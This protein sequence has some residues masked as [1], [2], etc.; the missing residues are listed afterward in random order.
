MKNIVFFKKNMV[1]FVAIMICSVSFFSGIVSSKSKLKY[2]EKIQNLIEDFDQ[3]TVK[4]TEDNYYLPTGGQY[5]GPFFVGK[6][7]ANF[8]NGSGWVKR[9][10]R[11]LLF[12]FGPYG[13]G[14]VELDKPFFWSEPLTFYSNSSGRL[15]G[16]RILVAVRY[17]FGNVKYVEDRAIVKGWCFLT[18]F[19]IDYLILHED[20]TI[21]PEDDS[22]VN[23]NYPIEN[24]GTSEFLEV[25][26]ND[27][28]EEMR[29]YIKFNIS[30]IPE[31]AFIHKA[32]LSLNYC[33]WDGP[34]E[35]EIGVYRV[36]NNWDEET[37][38]W[39]NQPDFSNKCE[40][41]WK[42]PPADPIRLEYWDITDLA[43]GW[44]DVDIPNHGIVVKF[45]N[46]NFEDF[47]KRVFNSK[48]AAN[49]KN[50]PL[51][52]INYNHPPNK[53]SKPSGLHFLKIGKT[54]NFSTST[55]D[56]DGDR[57]FF[58]F[59][60]GDDT[61]SGWVGPFDYGY[62]GSASHSWN[63]D[64]NYQIRVKAKDT[65]GSESEWSTPLNI[66]VYN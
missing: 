61:N 2:E 35:P 47:T 9:S 60:W 27:D 43:R 7:S 37:I 16:R 5:V 64:G 30:S 15:F 26:V 28:I 6:I 22:F 42:I 29:S 36:F 8:F 1:L 57:V 12:E 54:Y 10:G 40:Y 33:G 4:C 31:N 53:P 44:Y 20:L 32:L 21:L 48:E 41:H 59:D 56:T 3:L 24:Y 34:N 25:S 17:F 46:S 52:V 39:D 11:S 19:F 18:E 66:T 51:L 55:I 49:N 23:I 38:N 50:R 62:P 63:K 45:C 13:D 65:F 14:T 58:W